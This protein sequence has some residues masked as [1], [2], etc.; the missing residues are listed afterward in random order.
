MIKTGKP[1]GYLLSQLAQPILRIPHIQKVEFDPEF[2]KTMENF[3]QVTSY[4]NT[5]D[6]TRWAREQFAAEKKVVER[7]GLKQ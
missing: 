7:F 2:V 6:Y 3:D 4:L 1:D 5:A